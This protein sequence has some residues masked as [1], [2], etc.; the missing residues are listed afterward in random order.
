MCALAAGVWAVSLVV[1]D[2]SIVDSF[3]SLFFLLGALVYALGSDA[4]GA[5]AALLLVLV[6]LWAVRLAVYITW[7]NHGTGEDARYVAMRERNGDRFAVS[8]LWRVF[9]L[10][11]VLAWFI[12]QPLLAGVIATAPLNAL[13]LAGALLCLVGVFF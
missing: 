3:W 13:D 7:R 1:R 4:T 2:V 10:Q 6:S 5:R 12:S 9:L 8:S 11:A